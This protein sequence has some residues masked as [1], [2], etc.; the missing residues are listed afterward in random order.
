M[1]TSM[2]RAEKSVAPVLSIFQDNVLFLNHNLNAQAISSLRSEFY[3][4]TSG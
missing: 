3:N 1:L 2:R 4:M